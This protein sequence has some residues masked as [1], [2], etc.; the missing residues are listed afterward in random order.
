[1]ADWDGDSPQ[2]R[3]NIANVLASARADAENRVV[4]KV[5]TAKA[6]HKE[7]MAGLTVPNSIYVGRFRGERGLGK[8]AVRIGNVFGVAPQEV[9]AELQ[10]FETR[11]Q[12]VVAGLDAQ[13]PTDE[14]LDDDGMLAVIDLAAW[15]HSEWVRIHPLANGNGRTARV[16]ANFIL[17]RYGLPPAVQLRSRPG[18][19][20]GSAGASAMRGD[21]KPTALVFR[22]LVRDATSA[23]ARAAATAFLAR[24]TKP[25]RR[26]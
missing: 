4:P 22:A 21:W 1:M 12:E 23:T 2:L 3:L 7:M 17:M 8:C 26:T 19:G 25:S 16:W 14:D 15:A 10:A 5:S 9:G 11:L 24:K 20:Y 13:Y 18:G 6:W